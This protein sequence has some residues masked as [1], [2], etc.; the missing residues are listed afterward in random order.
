MNDFT[1]F[2]Q[3][4]WFELASLT[5][6]FSILAVLAWYARTRIRMLAASEQ[7]AQPAARSASAA[8]VVPMQIDAQVAGQEE[9]A[10][11][12]S[13]GP[14]PAAYP[15]A[16]AGQ[17]RA[18]RTGPLHQAMKWLQAPVNTRST[19]P[20]RISVPLV[21]APESYAPGHGGVGRM[22]SPLPEESLPQ[23]QAIVQPSLEHVGL[24]RGIIRWLRAPMYTRVTTRQVTRQV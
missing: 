4:Y 23:G 8:A 21:P 18:K 20:R 2:I 9:F 5:A 19:R 10:G 17:Q 7:E 16:A 1:D 6:Q 11:T 13:Q 15:T 12:V 22:L 24:L 3:D 14:Q